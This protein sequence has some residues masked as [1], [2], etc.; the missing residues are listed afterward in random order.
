MVGSV[1]WGGGDITEEGPVKIGPPLFSDLGSQN[2]SISLD[3]VFTLYRTWSSKP[4]SHSRSGKLV[5]ILED[6]KGSFS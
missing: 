4:S 2:L 3:G 5:D 1:G 6:L